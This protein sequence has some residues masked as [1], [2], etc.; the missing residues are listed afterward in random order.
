MTDEERT[1]D[2]Q[3]AE[4]IGWKLDYEF[5]DVL[6]APTVPHLRDQYD[7]WGI[8]PAFGSDPAAA[9]ALLEA[10]PEGKRHLV[11]LTVMMQVAPEWE[12]AR[13]P[14]GE[15][16]CLFALLLAPPAAIRDAVLE[17]MGE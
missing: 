10:V 4:A 6:G 11:A 1:K 8:L 2:T 17:V 12:H 7:E 13:G 3:A 15:G 16:G 9:R 5:E 14:K